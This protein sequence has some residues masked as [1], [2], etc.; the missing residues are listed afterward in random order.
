MATTYT[1]TTSFSA[2]TTAI[3][4]EVNQNFTDILDALNNG[5][6]ATNL[7]G[8]IALARISDL[9]AT[10]MA[11]TFFLDQ[12]AM[13]SNSATAVASQQSIVAY[14]AAQVAAGV[15]GVGFYKA[16]GTT[17]LTATAATT[18]N[19]FQDLDISATVGANVALLLIEVT[20]DAGAYIAVK[21]KGTGGTGTA[22]GSNSGASHDGCAHVYMAG[23]SQ[24]V[25]VVTATDSS[26]IF[27]WTA[28]NASNVT[29]KL[30][31]YVK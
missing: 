18:A 30:I 8:T 31:G 10:Q 19:T 26:G 7:T 17:I 6:D 24:Y 3:A 25:Y 5:F 28:N 4:S 9:T 2:D 22:H 13:G 11:S 23:G 16:S 1:V 21:P 27:Q 15:A 12:D 20:A 29:M 14:V